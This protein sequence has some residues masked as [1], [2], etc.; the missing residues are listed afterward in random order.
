[1][2]HKLIILFLLMPL[3]AE[4]D[5]QW[6]ANSVGTLTPNYTNVYLVNMTGGD[7]YKGWSVWTNFVNPN[8]F[9]VQWTEATASQRDIISTNANNT[10]QVFK[11]KTLFIS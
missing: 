10:N 4:A 2:R 7:A 8:G 1:M 9:V 3:L 6:A 11:I 5:L